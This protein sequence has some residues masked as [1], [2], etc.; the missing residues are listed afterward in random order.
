MTMYM[1]YDKDIGEMMKHAGEDGNSYGSVLRKLGTKAHDEYAK[2]GLQKP[3]ETSRR[4]ISGGAE[5]CR[6][7]S[8][9]ARES[10]Q[11][12]R[13]VLSPEADIRT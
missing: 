3:A 12:L 13:N 7:T 9:H 8:P 4:I 2:F 10:A 6:F 1:P 11:L 5:Y